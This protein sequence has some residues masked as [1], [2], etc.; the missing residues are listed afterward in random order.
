MQAN[1]C[2]CCSRMRKEGCLTVLLKYRRLIFNKFNGFLYNVINDILQNIVIYL[3]H[4]IF[5]IMY[6]EIYW[7]FSNSF[8]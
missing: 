4:F 2:L 6:T 1:I 5:K 3:M 8:F 7:I